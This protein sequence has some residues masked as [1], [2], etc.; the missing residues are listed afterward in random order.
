MKERWYRCAEGAL[1]ELP[2]SWDEWGVVLAVSPVDA[3]Q[4]FAIQESRGYPRRVYVTVF[5]VADGE[6]EPFDEPQVYAVNV[7]VVAQATLMEVK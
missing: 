4:A 5:G 3:A 2:T 1:D 6:F 7:K